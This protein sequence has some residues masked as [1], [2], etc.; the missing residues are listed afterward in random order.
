MP[1]VRLISLQKTDGLD[2]LHD[3]PTGMRIE[4]LGADFDAGPDAFADTAAIMSLL[5]LVITADT[6]IAHL[7]GA[8]GRSVWVALK[9]VPDWRWMLDR[10][11]TPWYPTMSP[12]R[13]EVRGDWAH[14]FQ[15][16]AADVAR[17]R[18]SERRGAAASA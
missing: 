11:N 14:V 6:S 1:G 4:T 17:L 7:A 8:L 10:S 18:P 15:C 5:D 9:Q 12:Y 3:L 2:Q 13:Q 16:I